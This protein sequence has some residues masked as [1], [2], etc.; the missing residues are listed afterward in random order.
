MQAYSICQLPNKLDVIY[1]FIRSHLKSKVI[2]FLSSCKQVKFIDLAF[3][4]LRPGIPLMCLHG[5]IKQQ[6]RMHIYYDFIRKP[7]A[8]LFATDV[9]ARGL[10]FPSVDWV[11]QADCPED[12][13]TYIH[14]VGRTAR[15]KNR[16]RSLLLLLPNEATEFLPLLK[17]ANIPISEKSLNPSKLQSI[18]NRLQSEVA[19]DTELK[20]N[21][22]R[23]F[24]SYIRSV[25]LQP[26]KNV[27]DVKQL[28]MGAF[29]NSLGLINT[30]RIKFAG[31]G[32]EIARSELRQL[33][34]IPHA[35]S[36]LEELLLSYFA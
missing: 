24:K 35:L 26:N 27:F 36:K 29:A 25:H 7:A 15:Y 17:N 19:K 8:I 16:G 23:A 28:P 33:K 10:D 1:S 13:A 14:R 3:S 18:G 5:K 9:A 31:Q 34:N 11:V 32:G 21:A 22:E 20:M 2:I 12:V 6:R 4:K 30:P